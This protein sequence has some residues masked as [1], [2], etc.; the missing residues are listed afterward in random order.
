MDGAQIE[1]LL[2]LIDEGIVRTKDECIKYISA[3]EIMIVEELK[4]SGKID[5]PT[6]AGLITILRSQLSS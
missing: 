2:S 5:I 6:S 4:R 1:R 3:N